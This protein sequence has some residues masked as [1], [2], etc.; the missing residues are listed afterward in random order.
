MSLEIKATPEALKILYDAGIDARSYGMSEVD[1]INILISILQS[2]TSPA[3]I[4][5]RGGITYS[6]VRKSLLRFIQ[7]LEAKDEIYPGV[8]ALAA[9][10][11][12]RD[13]AANSSRNVTALDIAI[14][15]FAKP[16]TLLISVCNNLGIM[17][18][19]VLESLLEENTKTILSNVG[20]KEN[21][22]KK[23]SKI[24]DLRGYGIELTDPSYVKTL[25]S[26]TSRDAEISR[27]IEVLCKRSKPNPIL[28]GEAGTGKTAIVEGLAKRIVAGTVPETLADAKI[29]SLDIGELVSGTRL[30]GDLEKKIQHIIDTVSKDKNIILFIDEIHAINSGGSGSSKT[31]ISDMLK[32]YLGRSDARLIGATTVDEYKKYIEV[33]E[34]LT[35][36]FTTIQVSEPDRDKSL[37]ILK[38]AAPTYAKYH[39]VTYTEDSL[40]CMVDLAME[41][42]PDRHMPDKALDLLDEAGAYIALRRGRGTYSD[43]NIAD[44]VTK[45]IVA[46]VVAEKTGIPVKQLQ[47]A[48]GKDVAGLLQ[49]LS[50]NFWG[51]Q[52][53]VRAL[54]ASVWRK[55]S[56]IGDSS[57]PASFLFLGPSGVGK[58]YLGTAFS[59]ALGRGDN[60][61]SLSMADYSEPF[62][63]SLLLGSA[64]GYVGYNESSPLLEFVRHHPDAVVIFD[65][66]DKAHQLVL[67]VLLQLL[68]E[69]S[70]TSGSGKKI[71]FSRTTVIITANVPP[72][73]K[74]FNDLSGSRSLDVRDRLSRTPGEIRKIFPLWRMEFLNRFDNIFM[75]SPLNYESKT[76]I[77]KATVAK[78]A[79]LV[80]GINFKLEV[81][82]SVID[83]LIEK[84]DALNEGARPIK[85]LVSEFLEEPLVDLVLTNTLKVG[86]RILVYVDKSEILLSSMDDLDSEHPIKA[87]GELDAS[88]I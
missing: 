40:A 80:S 29:F 49:T 6:E 52:E 28:I 86:S 87:L 84:C 78:L 74:R 24:N 42:M 18:N 50:N 39:K 21:V 82:E 17:P 70:L 77:I 43:L 20:P 66:A 53:A 85:K 58:S 27:I 12:A 26:I 76:N 88:Y 57:R 1:P 47:R 16:S 64:P 56:G 63:V 11:I 54:V 22:V 14:G 35:R 7:V 61:Y 8:A 2:S 45:D 23:I 31:S 72:E 83:F 41:H 67:D 33:D 68:E 69:G 15:I 75:F 38:N 46:A 44:V 10:N 19:L 55:Y 9:L 36:R 65:E 81:D 37:D 25:D 4:L 62:S 3:T 79:D 51:Q 48:G 5:T 73:K 32:P 13:S 30:R 59:E 60:V 71:D 34:A